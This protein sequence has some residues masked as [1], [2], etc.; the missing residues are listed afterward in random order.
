MQPPHAA[1]RRCRAV[2]I[3]HAADQSPRVRRGRARAPRSRRRSRGRT[4]RPRR[5]RRRA[6]RPAAPRGSSC[7]VS[8]PISTARSST[9]SNAAASRSSSAARRLLHAP[10]SRAAPA[11]RAVE[12]EQVRGPRGTRRGGRE[13]VREAR[14]GERGGLLGREAAACSR[15]F[16]RPGTH[17]LAMTITVRHVSGS[18]PARIRRC[19]EAC[20]AEWSCSSRRM[21]LIAVS[22][23]RTVPVTFERPT[24]GRYGDVELG[25]APA[26]GRAP[27]AASP[28]GSR[29]AGRCRPSASSRR[30]R[31]TRIG[32]E[33]VHRHAGGAA[34]RARR[35]ARLASRACSGPGAAADRGAR[36]PSTRS[37]LAGEHGL[38]EAGQVG[39]VEGARRRRRSPRASAVAASTPGVHRGA[40]AAPRLVHD[41]RRRAPRRPRRSRRS[42]R[43]R[44]RSPG[45]PA[46]ARASTHGSAA[47]SSRQRQH[48]VDRASSDRRPQRGGRE[49][50]DPLLEGHADPARRAR[51]ASRAD[52]A[53][54]CRTSPSR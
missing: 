41:E 31:A 43:C 51:R 49:L 33:V 38:G 16:T 8:M 24:R 12:P 23:P 34:D 46:A 53:V 42:S 2:D 35:A 25:D 27:R 50:G 17:S 10:R 32:P 45:S 18:D 11:A 30:R 28:A 1:R 47:A 13:R 7:G 48:D 40:E 39:G 26:R 22:V 19:A 21:S 4:R 44:R 37:A 14:G 29:C 5:S 3:G 9:A 6:T 52:D 20:S 54:M 15:V 36:R